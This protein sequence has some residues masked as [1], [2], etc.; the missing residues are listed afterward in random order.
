MA[1]GADNS[2]RD[3]ERDEVRAAHLQRAR[4][5]A[6]HVLPHEAELRRHLRRRAPSGFEVDDIVQE[7]YARLAGLSSVEH[8]HNPRSY[9]FRMA[10]GVMMDHLRRQKVVPM[11]GLDDLDASGAISAEPSPEAVA[12][13]KN[14]LDRFARIFAMLPPQ[15]A[16]VF[17][18]R[19]IEDLSQR[20]TALRLGLPES[21]I[22]K[23][24]ARGVYL[25]AQYWETGGN[26]TPRSTKHQ[27]PKS[28]ATLDRDDRTRDR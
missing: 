9:M 2:G 20:D 10:G 15:I 5:I 14:Q 21:T 16:E 7:I 22:E 17:R 23:R 6:S 27:S 25:V 3:G 11:H 1:Q 8:I 12:L 28:G 4:W 19:R 24:M 26:D 18:L 13:H